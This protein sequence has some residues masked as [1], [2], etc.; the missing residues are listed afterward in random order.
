[1]LERVIRQFGFTQT[2]PRNPNV[3]APPTVKMRDMDDLFDDFENHLVPEKARSTVTPD[4]W[5]Y[6]YGYMIWFFR[7]SHP[8]MIEDAPGNPPRSVHQEILEE[9]QAMRGHDHDVL[10]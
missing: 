9:E 4:D 2:I 6:E 7:V 10:L 8:Y 1:M 5:S 3:C